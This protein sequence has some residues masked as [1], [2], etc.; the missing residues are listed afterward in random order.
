M[1][2]LFPW[3]NYVKILETNSR[4]YLPMLYNS[5]VTMKVLFLSVHYVK[6]LETISRFYLPI[7][8]QLNNYH[9]SVILLGSLCQNVGDHFK[10]LH[11]YVC[12]IQ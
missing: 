9:E 10:I 4:F 1:K 6:I 2:V 11:P 5:T 7:F 3:V 12:T 8:V